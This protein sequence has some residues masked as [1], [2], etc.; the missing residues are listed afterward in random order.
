MDYLVLYFVGLCRSSFGLLEHLGRRVHSKEDVNA[1][2]KE[3]FVVGDEI[4]DEIVEHYDC[5]VV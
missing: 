1:V 5:L 3:D 4:L 2:E